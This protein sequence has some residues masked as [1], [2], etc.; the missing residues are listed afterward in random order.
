MVN[1]EE[2][3]ALVTGAKGFIGKHLALQLSSVGYSVCGI[4]H[5]LWAEIDA[6]RWGVSKWINGQVVSSNLDICRKLCGPPDL[7]VHLAGGSSVGVA[8]ENPHEDFIRSAVSTSELLNWIRSEAPEARLLAVSSAAVYGA[9]HLG[10]ISV[11]SHVNPY[12]PYGVHKL[13]MEDICR[14]Y[15]L[16]FGIKVS[17]ARL[18]SVY[19]RGLKK[20]LLWDLCS[21]LDAGE[22]PVVLGGGGEELR[23]WVNVKDVVR[24]LEMLGDTA[25]RNVPV[26]NVG[27]GIGTPVREVVEKLTGLW[28]KGS[29]PSRISFSGATRQGDPFSLVADPSDLNSLGFKVGV[30][31][32]Q[33][34]A[35]YVEWYR[36]ESTR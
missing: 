5:G 8:I 7:I 21:R 26:F 33:G 15:A 3:I 27:T 22:D 2:K 32:A 28:S 17:L 25:S 24:A 35:D 11:G 13:M 36:E 4:G 10:T 29:K 16:S 23:D 18:F 30:D 12:S 19:G 9:D 14:Y 1:T 34:L 6:K 20:Q 31:L